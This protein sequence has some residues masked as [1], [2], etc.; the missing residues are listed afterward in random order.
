VVTWAYFSQKEPFVPFAPSFFFLMGCENSPR[1]KILDMRGWWMQ[2]LFTDKISPLEGYKHV[3]EGGKC[4]S[5]SLA[6]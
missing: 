2:L 4:Y 5:F 1:K 6:F 3:A